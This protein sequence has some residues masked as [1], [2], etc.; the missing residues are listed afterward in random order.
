VPI[1][2]AADPAV[3][4]LLPKSQELAATAPEPPPA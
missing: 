3:E 2:A 1:D 4:A